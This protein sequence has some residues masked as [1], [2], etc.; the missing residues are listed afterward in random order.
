MTSHGPAFII[1]AA[2]FALGTCIAVT[3]TAVIVAV[4][5]LLGMRRE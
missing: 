2:A 4:Y 1:P 5:F 3:V